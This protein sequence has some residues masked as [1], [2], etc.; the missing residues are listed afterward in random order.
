MN[1]SVLSAL[2][3]DIPRGPTWS[4]EFRHACL[5][6]TVAAKTKG[7]RLA[8]YRA[9]ERFHGAPAAR[10]LAQEVSAVW[11]QQQGGGQ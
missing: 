8:F 6:R 11:R 1:G 10:R 7:E 3:P 9:W 5:L 4:P 2:L